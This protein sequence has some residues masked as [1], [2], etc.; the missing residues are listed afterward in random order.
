MLAYRSLPA[1]GPYSQ[2]VKANGM[3]YVSG[4]IGLVPETMK[5]V[6]E[7]TTEQANQVRIRSCN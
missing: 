5:M 3:V 6:A 1:I 4:M 7:S 2:A